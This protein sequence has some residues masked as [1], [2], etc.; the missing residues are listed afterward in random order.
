VPHRYPID[1]LLKG[2]IG[3]ELFAQAVR[4]GCKKV[5]AG[6]LASMLRAPALRDEST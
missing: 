3:G 5:A 1:L 4:I 6:S 2:Q